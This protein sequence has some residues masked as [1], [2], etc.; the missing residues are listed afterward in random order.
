MIVEKFS[1]SEGVEGVRFKDACFSASKN[2]NKVNF[3]VVE[4]FSVDAPNEFNKNH[5]NLV[6]SAEFETKPT[7]RIEG[8]ILKFTAD[9]VSY[10]QDVINNIDKVTGFSP[11]LKALKAPTKREDGE[12]FYGSGE[13]K[14]YST[15][16]LFEQ[17]AGFVGA[18]KFTVEKFSMNED[19]I[20]DESEVETESEEKKENINTEIKTDT[21]VADTEEFNLY[22][23]LSEQVLWLKEAHIN[24]E[25][26]I[27]ELEKAIEVLK[28]SGMENFSSE[29]DKEID[30][31]VSKLSI[32]KN[33]ETF[34]A[35]N[36]E[37]VEKFEETVSSNIS[38]A[39][40]SL[41]E[42]K[43]YYNTIKL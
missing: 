9:I 11:E 36:V 8:N 13:L 1:N 43:S 14:W 7:A 4:V 41:K 18:D 15:A 10:D 12:K 39:E 35:E 40:K 30:E 37:K 17:K 2:H 38:E 5:T 24:R 33:K 34:K 42:K 16:I 25:K 23:D 27:K 31:V 28:S 6:L 22:R 29:D 19:I 3:D 26:K 21:K 32:K 20:L